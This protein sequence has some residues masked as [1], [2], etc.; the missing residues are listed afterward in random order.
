MFASQMVDE[1]RASEATN[2]ILSAVL[3]MVAWFLSATNVASHTAPQH[4]HKGIL[5]GK[6]LDVGIS[7]GGV[8]FIIS[9]DGKAWR[10]GSSF[11]EEWS[12]VGGGNFV[13]VDVDQ[14]NNPWAVSRTGG[15]YFYN[16]VYWEKRGEGA[17]DIG[18][19]PTGVVLALLKAGRIVG[20]NQKAK[21][22]ERYLTG[23]GRRIDVDKA[24]RPWIVDHKGQVARHT[25]KKWQTFT[26]KARDI[27]VAPDGSVFI[28]RDNGIAALHLT[29]AILQDVP[30]FTRID[31][32]SAGPGAHLWAVREDRSILSMSLFAKE[33]GIGKPATA[34]RT[35]RP[36]MAELI[37]NQ[38]RRRSSVNAA[39]VTSNAPI[40]FVLV[41]NIRASDIGIGSD[42]SVFAV[43][44]DGFFKR[45]SERDRVFLD[46]PGQIQAVSADSKGNPWGVTPRGDV[47]RHNGTDWVKVDGAF[48]TARDIAINYTDVVFITD[49]DEN[50]FRFNETLGIFT[51]YPNL[52]GTR[53][54]VDPR[55]RPWTVDGK[56][57]VF[58]CDGDTGCAQ[59][60]A[61]DAV[62]IGIGPDGSIFLTSTGNA[63]LRYNARDGAFEFLPKVGSGVRIVDV[64]PRGRPWVIDTNGRVYA[65]GFFP[66]DE[67]DDA[68]TAQ[69]TRTETSS[70]PTIV[71]T[72]RLSLPR[73]TDVKR[74][75]ANAG[76]VR[77]S[78][79]GEVLVTADDGAIWR[80]DRD[81]LRF[82]KQGITA[83]LVP[84]SFG[85]DLPITAIS[86]DGRLVYLE[87]FP[88]GTGS[89]AHKIFEQR[90]IGR[91]GARLLTEITLNDENIDAR[92]HVAPEGIVYLSIFNFNSGRSRIFST[93]SRRTQLVEIDVAGAGVD[94]IANFLSV[95]GGGREGTL[96]TVFHNI[97][98]DKYAIQVLRDGRFEKLFETKKEI[99]TFS[100]S[101]KSFYACL[102]EVLS[103]FNTKSKRFD[104]TTTRCVNISVTPEDLVFYIKP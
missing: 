72:K 76:T 42:G 79:N 45:F 30:G 86:P 56:G 32:L 15:I 49:D 61:A 43:D 50:V 101:E 13:R 55:G 103:R 48:R 28:A 63:L 12:Y 92:I 11:G 44:A 38:R 98:S 2:A 77:S 17:I 46:F 20:W 91:K 68:E 81:K 4:T 41:P 6:A 66:R 62:D 87:D 27:S 1:R 22:F 60:P 52:K 84:Q 26:T 85:P 54:A 100:S 71:F 18:V 89:T 78:R 21:R 53:I 59:T 82:F 47:F 5:K 96:D 97:A 58:R 23:K 24:G 88:T 3:L 29:S 102:D 36:T 104:R 94:P 95:A 99:T 51:L 57:D 14:K 80:F 8:T 10:W 37:E 83:P 90:K 67:T 39:I 7:P 35:G 34:G 65:S 33:R 25:G 19:G 75:I 9:V 40:A 74:R 73:Y 70:V 31:S 16:S 64:G 93:S 69:T